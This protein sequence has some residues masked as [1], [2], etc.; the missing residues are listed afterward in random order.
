M[1][2]LIQV[3][4]SSFPDTRART[5]THARARLP[6]SSSCDGPVVVLLGADTRESLGHLG[7]LGGSVGGAADFGSGHDLT[8]RG[9][10]PRVGL[11]ADGSEPGACSGS[12]VSLCPTLSPLVLPCFLKITNKHFLK[13]EL[14][15]HLTP[16]QLV[17]PL[18]VCERV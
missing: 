2:A 1:R 15:E 7:C 6:V 5:H 3:S 4:F 12:S 8:V 10:E 13:K 9:F 11:C 14:T 18:W 17:N 16:D